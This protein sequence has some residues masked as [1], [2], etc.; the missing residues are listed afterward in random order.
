M[1]KKLSL[2]GE[3]FA[4][5]GKLVSYELVKNG[6]INSTYRVIYTNPEKIYIFQ[7]LNIFVF[8]RPKEMMENIDRITTHIQ[9]KHPNQEMLHFYYTCTGEN[10]YRDESGDVWRI[11]NY[12]R[13]VT[14]NTTEDLKIIRYTGEAFGKFQLDLADFDASSLYETIPDF[15]NT[16]KRLVDLCKASKT[17]SLGRAQYASE[18]IAYI[19]SVAKRACELCDQYY[20]GEFPI[21]VT[22]NDTKSNNVLYDIETYQPLAVVDLDTVMPGMA[23]YDFGDAVRF[24]ANTAKEDEPNLSKVSFDCEK[25]AAYCQGYI[26]CVKEHLTRKELDSMVLGA[27]S[28]TVE[29]AARFLTDYLIGD[30]YFRIDY[31]EHNLVRAKCQLHLA[32]DIWRQYDKLCGIVSSKL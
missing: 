26:G 17:D 1:L 7:K 18:E 9:K 16:H 5:P 4:L 19:E 13:S 25:F 3:A 22:H 10:I 23:M 20:A 30:I 14:F 28:V 8:K 31:P 6:N 27:F 12:I 11:I 32:K 29:L 21:R 2:I 15:H 24:I